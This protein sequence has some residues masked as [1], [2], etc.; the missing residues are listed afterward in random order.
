MVSHAPGGVCRAHCIACRGANLPGSGCA[1]LQ[2]PNLSIVG[3]YVC[4]PGRTRSGS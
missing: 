1:G 3:A 2:M 4:A